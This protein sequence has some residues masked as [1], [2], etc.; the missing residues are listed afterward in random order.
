[1]KAPDGHTL[2]REGYG[3]NR[4]VKGFSSCQMECFLNV[5]IFNYVGIVSILVRRLE[6]RIGWTVIK[7]LL[8]QV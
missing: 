6:S 1:M 4:L 5:S 2:L 3:N 7:H 8:L